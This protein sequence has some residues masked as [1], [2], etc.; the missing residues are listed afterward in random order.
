MSDEKK[1]HKTIISAYV[2]TEL[3]E[4]LDDV[5]G[6]RERSSVIEDALAAYLYQLNDV[7]IKK[8]AL[9]HKSESLDWKITNL[10]TKRHGLESEKERIDAEI[11]RID[12]EIKEISAL[13]RL[14]RDE[15]A[16]LDNPDSTIRKEM[17]TPSD[18]PDFILTGLD[19]RLEE[20][21]GKGFRDRWST[22]EGFIKTYE[23]WMQHRVKEA[24]EKGYKVKKKDLYKYIREYYKA[25]QS[26]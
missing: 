4:A 2:G 24:E 12:E 15:I 13:S 11:K 19:E 1:Q 5:A 16:D 18:I 25:H 22:P 9:L 21:R 26:E 8:T 17:D 20:K 23:T 6:K 14:T 7:S 10:K 3:V